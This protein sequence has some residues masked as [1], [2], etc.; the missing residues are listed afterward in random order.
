MSSRI[1]TLFGEEP[2]PEALNAA[3]SL[4]AAQA[5]EE[6]AREAPEPEPGM[7]PVMQQGWEASKQYYAIGE[8]AQLFDVKTSHIRFWTKEFNLKVRTTRKG[9][10]LYTQAHIREL[11]AIYHLVK[12]RGFTIAGAK[13]KLKEEKKMSSADV[14]DLRKSLLLLRNQLVAIRNQLK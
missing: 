4:K 13:T 9:D 11:K 8:V 14:V 2:V 10:R 6:A 7:P 3:G 12:E 1:L 5:G